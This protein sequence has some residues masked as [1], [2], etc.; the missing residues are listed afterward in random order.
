MRFKL[1]F[2]LF[3]V[4]FSVFAT[5]YYVSP[6]GDNSADGSINSPWKTPGYA[7]KQLQPGDTLIILSGEY[8]LETFWDDMITPPSGTE[9]N[10]IT[11]KGESAANK[12]VLRG[13]NNLLSAID[14]GGKSYVR[15]ENLEITNYNGED[16]REGVESWDECSHIVLK[17]LY[18]H[19][20]DE[21]GI[22]IKD[23]NDLTIE[24]VV[25]KYCGFGGIGGPAGDNGGWRNV[26]IKN[27]EF[28]YSGHYYRGQSDSSPYDRPD[29]LG[30]EPSDGPLLVENCLFA[31]NKGDGFDSKCRNTTIKKSIVA[32]NSCDGLKLWGNNSKA[33][34]CL[35]FGRGDGDLSN[36]PWG[37]IVVDTEENASISFI[38]CTVYQNPSLSGY[39]MY[40]Q[41]S[42]G[43]EVT[44]TMINCIVSGGDSE[45][46]F[47]DNVNL[48]FHHNLLNLSGDTKVRYRGQAYTSQNISDLGEGIILSNPHFVNAKDG[49]DSDFHLNLDSPA[50]DS[51]YS[52]DIVPEEDIEGNSRPYGS[53][54]DIGCYEYKTT[55]V[56][57]QTCYIPHIA[58]RNYTTY[59][60][61]YSVNEENSDF[62]I[63][64][65]DDSGNTVVNK[66]YSVNS[67]NFL[68]INL[69]ELGE[70]YN[71]KAGVIHYENGLV[72][73]LAYFNTDGGMAEFM[74]NGSLYQTSL[75]IFP[76][77]NEEIT[78]NG[79]AVF[80]P[81][82][83]EVGITFTAYKDGQV[84]A[85][86]RLALQSMRNIVD[87]V[88]DNSSILPSLSLH[89]YDFIKIEAEAGVCG[90]NISGVGQQNLVFL[91]LIGIEG[92]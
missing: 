59:L 86:Q 32:N 23:C 38:N 15:I 2:I 29:G 56:Y 21:M 57:N 9:D 78:W 45:V 49:D 54:V 70:D 5:T 10:W 60:I 90:L 66:S 39:P 17:N 69:R 16:F 42:G 91:P 28:S 41:Y 7:S 72:F 76:S 52:G 65:F 12:P 64:L 44:L 4:S 24:S 43:G 6:N 25:V 83:R 80:N 30:T 53:G 84:V 88:G 81:N 50:I 79:I 67:C 40:V 1:F 27:S 62:S 8:T 13:R 36:T 61:A 26:S 92:E 34:N 22:N 18:I 35:V 3:F 74:L 33:V 75:A 14:I 68:K 77:Y 20:V 85:T 58:Y 82:L 46:Y 89:D 19:H 51:G 55:P 63:S 31:H 37:S 71:A 73:K 48:T 47:G 11:I 87:V